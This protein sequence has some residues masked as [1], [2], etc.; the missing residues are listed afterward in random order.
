MGIEEELGMGDSLSNNLG[1][2][3]RASMMAPVPAKNFLGPV[4]GRSWTKPVAHAGAG[5]DNPGVLY[6]GIFRGGLR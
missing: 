3:T 5:Y 2:V 1:G 6:N 4:P